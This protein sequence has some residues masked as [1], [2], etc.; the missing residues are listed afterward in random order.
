MAADAA[1]DPRLR[2]RC[3]HVDDGWKDNVDFALPRLRAAGMPALLFVVADVVGRRLPFYQE[4]LVGGWRLG[5]VGAADLMAAAGQPDTRSDNSSGALRRAIAALEQLDDSER[6][7]ALAGFAEAMDDGH[8]HMVVSEELAQLEQGG[9]AIGL[10]GKTHTPMTRA[11]DLE[12]ELGGARTQVAP[13]L[14]PPMP[15]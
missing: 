1:P 15:R 11:S 14:E 8:R 2:A 9:V 5:K 7:A 13:Y 3:H 12:A 4:R 6:E 10:H